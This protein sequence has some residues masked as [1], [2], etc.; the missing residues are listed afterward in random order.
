[1]TR[2][3]KIARL[4]QIVREELNRRLTD[5][6]PGKRLVD[7]L[8]RQATVQAVLRSDFAN[9]PISEQNLSEWKQG[10]FEDWRRHRETLAV[11]GRLL[12]EAEDLEELDNGGFG[13][14]RFAEMA[15]VVIAS[16]LQETG[17]MAE[18]PEKCRTTLAVVRELIQLRR[19]DRDYER[20]KREE[21][22]HERK[23]NDYRQSRREA[24]ERSVE[25]NAQI[26][27]GAYE[28]GRA[29]RATYLA[30]GQPEPA[31]LADFLAR[32]AQFKS[33]YEDYRRHLAAMGQALLQENPTKSDLIRPDQT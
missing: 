21:E 20:A 15:T 5:G 24:L 2:T 11:A 13:A 30:K 14:D 3:G 33:N 7:W 26:L 19:A 12:E 28:T 8:N 29:V 10:G 9:R 25:F 27:Q 17:R 6:E 23:T 1:M 4:P 31:E 22:L 16:L 32:E 18:G